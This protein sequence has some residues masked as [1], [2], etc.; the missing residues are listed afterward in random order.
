MRGQRGTV[1]A[2]LSRFR[3]LRRSLSIQSISACG[4]TPTSP[5]ILRLSPRA[6]GS[7]S[8]KARGCLLG[9]FPR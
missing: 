5:W 7:G 1:G 2:G 8:R 6:I 4:L 3:G 9:K